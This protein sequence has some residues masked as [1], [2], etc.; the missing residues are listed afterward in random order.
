M[1]FYSK[2]IVVADFESMCKV[3]SS[4]DTRNLIAKKK[5]ISTRKLRK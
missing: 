2:I 3:T 5:F 4:S 1:S